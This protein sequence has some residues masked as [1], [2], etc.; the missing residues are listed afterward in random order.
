M[1]KL[2]LCALA[3]FAFSSCLN[4][5]P[6]TDDITGKW[7]LTRQ[8][9]GDIVYPGWQSCSSKT[10]FEFF[11][12]GKVVVYNGCTGTTA[13]GTYSISG[14]TLKLSVPGV[15]TPTLNISSLTTETLVLKEIGSEEMLLKS[16]FK[17]VK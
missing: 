3:F 1:K 16:I 10:T 8:E 9:V 6:E 12:T 14:N 11:S 4:D 17:K 15:G 13:E 5:E 2:L 7:R